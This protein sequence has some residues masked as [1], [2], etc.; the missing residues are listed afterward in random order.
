[1]ELGNEY[2]FRYGK[3][4]RSS[5]VIED[6]PYPRNLIPSLGRSPSACALKKGVWFE[7]RLKELAKESVVEAYNGTMFT[8]SPALPADAT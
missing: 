5:E 4:H 3:R 2:T 1:M 6:L 7:E 8:I